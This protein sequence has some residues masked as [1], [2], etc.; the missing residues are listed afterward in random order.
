MEVLQAPSRLD[1]SSRAPLAATKACY[2]L[3][4]FSNH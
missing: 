4:A 1:T 2:L 3:E